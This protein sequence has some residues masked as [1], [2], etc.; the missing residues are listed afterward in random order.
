[1]ADKVTVRFEQFDSEASG[2]II[3]SGPVVVDG[4]LETTQQLGSLVLR[5]T[6]GDE[7]D[8]PED[9][10]EDSFYLENSSEG[11]TLLVSDAEGVF[12]E[13]EIENGSYFFSTND[14]LFYEF[15]NNEW[16]EK[17][18]QSLVY[19]IRK[20]TE[21]VA[22]GIVDLRYR[23]AYFSYRELTDSW[24]EILLGTHTHT[25]KDFLDRLGAVDI[26]GPVGTKK[27]F[28]LEVKDTDD[29][30]A[31]YEY[32]LNWE[33]FPNI[34][35]LPETPEGERDLYLGFDEDGNPE[36]KNDFIAAQT[37]QLKTKQVTSPTL[38]V[39]FEDVLFDSTL[40]EVLVLAGKFFVYNRTIAYNAQT[41]VLTVNLVS[42]ED[43]STEVE[44]FEA[45]ET[46]SILIIRNGASAILDSLAKDYITKAEAVT[47]LSGGSVNLNDY[48]KKTDLQGYA[49]KYHT[50]SQFAR[51]DHNH[52]YRY[53][54]FNHTHDN[55]LTRKSA[56]SLIEEVL[57]KHPDILTS[58][59]AISDYIVENSPELATLAT[60]TDIDDIQAQ[61]DTINSTFG[62]RVQT[63]LDSEA[64]VQS[65]RVI[66]NFADEAGNAKNLD[67]V[68]TEFRADLD[69]D[70]GNVHIEEVF[71][72]EEIPVILAEDEYQGNYE[73]GD[74]ISETSN[75]TE[76][77]TNLFQRRIPPRSIA[78]ELQVEFDAPQLV[79]VGETIEVDITANFDRRDS[80]ML[81]RYEIFK[82]IGTNPEQKI[83]SFTSIENV[84]VEVTAIEQP[85]LLR[86]EGSYETGITK[87]DN[88]DTRLGITSNPYIVQAGDTNI[89]VYSMSGKRALF[90]GGYTEELDLEDSE[91]SSM[92]RN[93]FEKV[94]L[95]SYTNF[96]IESV[97]P[98]ESEYILFALPN[99]EGSLSKILY[100]DQGNI[101]IID[102]FQI[103]QVSI[104]GANGSTPVFY[105]VYYYRLPIKTINEMSLI[106]KK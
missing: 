86:V 95:A 30:E 66:T 1:M 14:N 27:F 40:D 56:L 51:V 10:A 68:L 24:Q 23:G 77:L 91:V 98:E 45:G 60:R 104:S 4:Q 54:M 73:N 2:D 34:K 7:V 9:A 62:T 87:Y 50:H 74:V 37:F 85:T 38:S 90:H 93:N 57:G 33:D 80:G 31:T 16:R 41:K 8:R 53:A 75:L 105:K 94:I 15:K 22:P 72:Q 43:S 49:K 11:Y 70:Y 12:T 99:S 61:I 84:S 3:S 82:T 64:T 5:G 101:N 52:D 106:F 13:Y 6:S 78:G 79:E 18:S 58:L 20:V 100:K 25:N 17:P 19:Y 103:A 59:Q 88:I 63:F 47:L 35:G 92:I 28:T 44:A 42:D 21:P 26:D 96:E 83:E 36:W 102:K 32:D 76:V 67:Q 97:I 69:D 71:L 89:T 46:I 29:S 81:N 65:E 48:A 55:Y 39:T